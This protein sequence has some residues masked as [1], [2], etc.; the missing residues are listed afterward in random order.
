[1]VTLLV[2]IGVATSGSA[3][4]SSTA[5]SAAGDPPPAS[6]AAVQAGLGVKSVPAEIVFLVDLSDS[7]SQNGLYDKVKAA[8]P[9]YLGTLAKQD[10]QDNIDV[11][12]FGR[13]AQLL[14]TGPPTSDIGLPPAPNENRTDFGQAFSLAVDRL[15]RA[16]AGTKVGGV[17][18][19]SDGE[20]YAIGDSQYETYKS[21]GWA[22]LRSTAADLPF[23]VT[24]YAVPLT[25]SQKYITNQQ[26]ALAVVFPN[27]QT[28][29]Q[30][31]TDLPGALNAAGDA[32]VNGAVKNAAASDSDRGVRVTWSGLP[33]PGTQ[34]LDLRTPGH[35]DVR[36]TVTAMTQRVPLYLTGLRLGSPGLP[37]TVSGTLPADQDLRAG[38]SVTFPVQ[39]TWPGTTSGWSLAGG[40]QTISGR[41]VLTGQVGSTY[42][43]TLRSSFGVTFSA[44][45]L[46]GNNSAPFTG[47]EATTGVLI[48]LVPMILL[49]FV[50]ACIL[51][52]RVRLRGKL[53]L[54]SVDARTGVLRL[55]PFPWA[56]AHTQALVG[57]PGRM[58]VRRSLFSRRDR[59]TMR[60]KLRLDNRPTGDVELE[61]GGRAMAVGIDIVHSGRR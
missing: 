32:V 50:L 26:Q 14:Y 23:K 61:P 38:T 10:P 45:D 40:S 60:I 44:G 39:L 4:A 34:P 31:A 9:D 35:L 48:F 15:G 21:P 3:R 6:S 57:I 19:M 41:L 2:T 30:S 56:W 47:R 8:L 29:P 1:L 7:M 52:F 18:L 33:G 42:T 24:G 51:L 55:P 53:T 22:T 46:T 58:T 43:P 17:V 13:S 59:G 28:L 36:V 54:T 25:T 5:S 37:L 20:L 27:P 49:L 16:P 11:I 12:T